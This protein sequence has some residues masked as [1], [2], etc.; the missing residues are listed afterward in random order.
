M[1]E[2]KK[3]RRKKN[4]KKEGRADSNKEKMLNG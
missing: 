4:R 1:R 2:M 3:R